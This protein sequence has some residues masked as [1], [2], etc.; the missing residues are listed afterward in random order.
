[1]AT[2]LHVF[3]DMF[4]SII[5]A[6]DNVVT[7]ASSWSRDAV[8]DAMSLNKAMLDFEFIITLYVVEQYLSYTEN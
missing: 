5:K 6:L 1:M 3:M 7:N 8:V 4:D 2:T